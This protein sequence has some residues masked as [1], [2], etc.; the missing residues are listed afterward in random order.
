ME[1]DNKKEYE[2][3]ELIQHENLNE[4]T[5]GVP[6]SWPNYTLLILLSKARKKDMEKNNKKEY[7]KPEL[8]EHENLNEVTKRFSTPPNGD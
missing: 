8:V 7:E 3:P 2:K 1:K 4:V 5:K 6:T